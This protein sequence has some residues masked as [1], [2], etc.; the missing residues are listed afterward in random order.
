MRSGSIGV[1]SILLVK[2]RLMAGLTN[3]VCSTEPLRGK[4]DKSAPQTAAEECANGSPLPAFLHCQRVRRL[5]SWRLDFKVV[6]RC[7]RNHV[8]RRR[9]PSLPRAITDR[10]K[11]NPERR[12]RLSRRQAEG[13]KKVGPIVDCDDRVQCNLFESWKSTVSEELEAS[14]MTI[15]SLS[16]ANFV[17]RMQLSCGAIE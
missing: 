4:K 2:W 13:F 6:W 15:F 7:R 3:S 12:L 9:H 8:V 16:G 17:L 1:D 14:W 11:T 10:L 5:R